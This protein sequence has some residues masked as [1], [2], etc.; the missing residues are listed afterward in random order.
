MQ[1]WEIILFS[2]LFGL[3][4]GLFIGIWLGQ[5]IIIKLLSENARRLA[6]SGYELGCYRS[7]VWCGC[8]LK[9]GRKLR[10]V[11]IPREEPR[12][13]RAGHVTPEASG[14]DVRDAR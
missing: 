9:E 3:V 1:I 14:R 12:D 5:H 2:G 6:E 7:D 11:W 13:A 8:D 4:A 10:N